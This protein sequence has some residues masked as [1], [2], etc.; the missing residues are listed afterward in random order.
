MIALALLLTL[1]LVPG[2]QALAQTSTP[3]ASGPLIL[4]DE[5]GEYP[6]GLHLEI[7]EDPGGELTIE[8][9][10]SLEF[11]SR[12]IPSLVK[13]PNYGFTDSAYWVRFR[14][15]NETRHTEQ[16]LLDV[17]FANMQY[18]DLFTPLPDGEE[19]TVKQT[20][21]LRPV[22]TRDVPYPRIIFDLTNPLQS[23]QTYYMRF[24]NGASMTLPLTLRTPD[25]FLQR[26]LAE[27][28]LMGIFYGVLIGLLLYNL[29]LLFSLRD[30]N[31]LFFVIMLASLI[32]EEA[33]YA[34]YMGMYIIP[35]LYFLNKYTQPLA[36]PLLIAAMLLF[37]DSF[38]EMRARLPR[39]HRINLVILAVWGGLILLALFASYHLLANLMAPWALFS[40]LAVFIAG[41]ASW[42]GG[43]RPARFF[44]LA[45]FGML[46]SLAM[47][48]L[49][50]LGLISSTLLSENIYRLGF[51]WMAVCW[52]IALADR[53]NLLKAE[54]ESANRALR[55]SEHKLSQILDGL[56][57]GV[58]VYGKDQKPTYT[59]RRMVEILS[60]P[61]QGI[62]VDTSVRR[63]ISQAIKYFSFRLVGSGQE[64]PLE[65]FPV[66]NALRGEPAS[67]D[68]IEAILGD[69][70]VPLEIWA[71]P[72]KDDAGNVE[73]AVVAIQDITQRKHAEVELDDY[74]KHLEAIVENR[75]A[76]LTAVNEQLNLRIDW[77]SSINQVNQI[78]ASS[79]DFNQIYAR[80]IEI[81]NG[82]FST[83]DSFIAELDEGSR[84]WQILAHSC[85]SDS[86]PDLM[87]SVTSLPDTLLF[88]PD[89]EQG[90]LT[91]YSKDQ[92]SSLSGPIGVHIRTT[93]IYSIALVPLRLRER[94]NGFLGL[95][96]QDKDR[97]ITPDEISLLSILSIDIAQLIEDRRLFEQAKAAITIEERNRLARDLH[98]SVTQVLFSAN[99]LAEVLPQIWRR[100]PEQGLQRL[101]K[102]QRLTRG[103][104]AEMRTLLLELRPAA[105]INTPL[106]ELL[107]QLAEAITS[108]SGLPFQLFIAQIP[109]LPEDVQINFYH[110]A[111]EALN[112]VVK[113]AQAEQVTLSLSST[114]LP[115]DSTSGARH[116]IRLVIEDD[117]VGYA[118]ENGVPGHLG[119]GIMRER[120]AAI[121]AD[122]S[123]ESK[124]GYGTQVTLIWTNEPGNQ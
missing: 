38:L 122:L 48:I 100:D 39:L 86:H 76:E 105:V 21:I 33:V 121:H 32:V 90:A 64:Y 102:L 30:A 54:T 36:F 99:L 2:N 63:T 78:M 114:P 16:W 52:S 10:S 110:I 68:D 59:N 81:I 115:S 8:E 12:F 15:D 101:E 29:F 42:K 24:E 123:L 77:L 104:L 47:L 17:G 69:K 80:I 65:K 41:L 26:S 75:T 25:A 70:R 83:Q 46:A 117:G 51:V 44:M 56:P 18:V 116:E 66:I 82:L 112:N 35:D 113:H 53:I 93:P 49:I 3:S 9:V 92:F 96:I 91:I 62:Q 60:N 119:T 61:A 13:V 74:R 19:F 7:L 98:D 34:G 57:L 95:E 22:S 11:D 28:T 71:S 37:S 97:I 120:A 14:L 55:N 106:G 73:S 31:Y 84:Q 118:S 1:G 67:A 72:V 50:R 87:G 45:W 124:P 4:T 109:P 5:Q 85:L 6:L 94:V 40:L 27:R 88:A 108:R 89:L 23:Q 79:A 20:G 58:V 43:F 103:A 107:S 111:E